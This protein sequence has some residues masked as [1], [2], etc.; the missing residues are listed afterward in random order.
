MEEDCKICGSKIILSD[1]NLYVDL[2]KR[3]LMG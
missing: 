2:L 3:V 1:T